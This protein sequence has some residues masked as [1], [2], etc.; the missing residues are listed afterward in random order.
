MNDRRKIVGVFQS[1]DATLSALHNLREGGF[2]ATK[3]YSPARTEE[4]THLMESKPSPVRYFT[5]A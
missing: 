5:L 4:I 3:V 2:R 1:L